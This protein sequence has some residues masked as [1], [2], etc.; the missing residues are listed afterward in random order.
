MEVLCERLEDVRNEILVEEVNG[1]QSKK[2]ILEGICIQA[3]IPNRNGRIY[4]KSVIK[5]VIDKYI[6]D[7][8]NKNMAVGHLNHPDEKGDIRNNPKEISHKFESLTEDGS[9]WIGRARVAV[10][11]PNGDIVAGL[12][13]A[14]IGMGISTRALGKTKLLEDRTTRQQVK[15]VQNFHL[16]SPGDIVMDPSAPDAY[17]TALMENKEWVWENGLLVE[18]EKEI[19]EE[20]N[21]IARAGRLDEQMVDLFKYLIK[22]NSGVK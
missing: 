15:V 5:P 10:G 12:M 17:L 7:V 11:T 8:L 3:D 21:K 6:N 20:V 14:G 16:L 9:N 22:M 18:R 4:P 19:K 2:Y 1:K 13:D